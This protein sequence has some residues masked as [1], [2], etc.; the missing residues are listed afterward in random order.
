MPRLEA[1][2]R[3]IPK[4]L[5]LPRGSKA[6]VL[7]C[8]EAVRQMSRLGLGLGKN[9]LALEEMPWPRLGLGRNALNFSRH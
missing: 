8:L 2:S 7:P 6:N 4:C 9:A 3:R 1:A 5:A